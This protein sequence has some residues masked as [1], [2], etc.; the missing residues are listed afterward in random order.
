MTSTDVRPPA[1]GRPAA[2]AAA[3]DD[4]V[5]DPRLTVIG[6]FAETYTA[7]GDRLTRQVAAHGVAPTEFEVLVRLLRSKGL[8]RMSDLAAQTA[9]TTS[10]VTRVVDRLA[11]RGLVTRQACATDRRATYAVLTD[12]GRDLMLA[13]L[14]GHLELVEA[15]LTGPLAESGELEAFTATLRRLRDHAAPGATAGTDPGSLPT[16]LSGAVVP[17]GS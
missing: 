5:H 7:I 4:V 12:A 16:Q 6:L 14:P 15:W 1:S 3:R 10:G 8:L 13:V 2:P 11:Q 17:A 9:L